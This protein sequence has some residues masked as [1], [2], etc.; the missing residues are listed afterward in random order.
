MAGKKRGFEVGQ[1]VKF[2]RTHDKSHQLTGVIE[3]FHEEDD[4]V[5]IKATPDGKAVEIE[6]GM[7]AHI[8]DIT[9]A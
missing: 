5:D 7:V 6:T 9:A 3:N 4:L 1:T 2:Y 8:S